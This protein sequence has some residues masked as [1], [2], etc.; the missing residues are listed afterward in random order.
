MREH[1]GVSV[2]NPPKQGNSLFIDKSAIYIFFFNFSPF[3]PQ[4]YLE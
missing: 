1:V 4:L 2:E 3:Q